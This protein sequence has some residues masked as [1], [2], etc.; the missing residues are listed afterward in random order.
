MWQMSINTLRDRAISSST[1]TRT[2][3]ERR[4]SVL[5]RSRAIRTY[6]FRRANGICEA[7]NTIAPFTTN[8]DRPYLEAHHIRRLSDGGPDHP[9]HVIAVCPNCHIGARF[10]IDGEI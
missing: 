9:R 10:S 4:T 3:A 1:T 7:C 2:P 8:S 6:I 5:Y